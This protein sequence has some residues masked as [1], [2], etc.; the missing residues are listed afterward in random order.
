MERLSKLKNQSNV[1][2]KLNQGQQKVYDLIV[3]GHNVFCSGVG[4][5]GKSFLINKLSEDFGHETVI[6]STTGISA[7]NIG[8]ETFHSG[9]SIPIGHPT[10][11]NMKKISSRVSKLFSKGKIKKIIIDEAG[12]I[13]PGGMYSFTQRLKKF[14][15]NTKNDNIQVI[16]FCDLGQLGAIVNHEEKKLAKKDYKTDKFY[17]I[18][19]YYTSF[20]R[21]KV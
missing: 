17:R 3:D 4:G 7:V 14:K 21:R 8:G 1:L 2:S 20:R 10:P 15:K 18:L 13:T 12:M 11:H 19:Q 16:I 9:L 6:V 5:T